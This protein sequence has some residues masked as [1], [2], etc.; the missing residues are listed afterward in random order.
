MTKSIGKKGLILMM[1]AM[2]CFSGNTMAEVRTVVGNDP[3]VAQQSGKVTGT[4]TDDF[5][6]VAGAAVL[7][8]GTTNGVVTDA[9]GRFTL[10]G[11]KNGA[12]I[13]VSYLGYTTQEIAFTGQQTLSIVLKEDAQTLDEVVVTALGVTKEAKALGYAVSTISAKELTKVGTP[14]FATALYGKAAGVRIYSAPGGQTS[15]VSMTVRGVSSMFGNTQPLL[16]MD[17]VPIRN[18]NANV[19][20]DARR[21]TQWND[22]RIQGNGIID[23][24][25]EDIENIS[26]LKGAA[27]SALYGS[28][29]ANGVVIVTSKKSAKNSGV[30]VDFSTTHSANMVA[31]MPK[32]QTEYGPGDL[33]TNMSAYELQNNGF[34]ERTWDRW[35]TASPQTY[36]SI[37]ASEM[38]NRN[39]FGAKYDGSDVLYWDGQVRPYSAISDSPYSDVFRTGYNQVYNVA[40]SHGGDKSSMR[41]SY[42]YVD[43]Q[44]TQY[45][46]DYSK[47]NFNLTG[48][49]NILN[50]LKIDYT[51]NYIRQTIHNRVIGIN[52][53][54]GTYAGMTG[55]F[56]DMA[57]MRDQFS[58][59]SGGYQYVVYEPT[60][61]NTLTPLETYAFQPGNFD[62]MKNMFY[63]M[64]GRNNDEKNQRFIA[65]V[66][67][68]WSI[69]KELTLRGRLSTDLT[70]EAQEERN[71]TERP[72]ALYPTDPGGGYGI[73]NKNYEI[74]YGDIMLMFNKDVADKLNLTA[75]V[76]FQGRL[77]E[78]RA[79][80]I[81]TRDGLSVDNWFHINASRNAQLETG[82]EYTDML[83]TA[84]FGSV[85]VSYDNTFYLEA[86]GRQETTSTLP[87]KNN[88]YFYP[89][90][91]ASYIFSEHLQ[92]Q[93]PWWDFGKLR[94]SYG[95]V[96]NA[97]D[98][99]RAAIVYNLENKDG[100]LHAST[101]GDYGNDD[102]K[103]EIKYEFEIGLESRFLNN[104][105]G[106][107]L[108]YYNNRVTDQLI[109]YDVPQT[110]GISRVWQNMG[111][112]K[113]SGVELT[114]SGTPVQTR[115]FRWD[116][117]FNYAVNKNEVTKLPEELPYLD[118]RAGLGNTGSATSVR[119]YVGRPV[120]EIFLHTRKEVNGMKVVGDY[121]YVPDSE[122]TSYGHLMPTAVGGFATTFAYKNLTLDMMFDFSVGGK[123]LETWHSYATSMGI[124]E[125]SLQYR[126][127]EHGGEAYYFE[128]SNSIANLREGV[129]PNGTTYYDG[130]RLTGVRSDP[131][132]TIIEKDADG[133]VI[134]TYSEV[135]KI[136]P[137]SNYYNAMYQGWGSGAFDE[138]L[139]DNSYLKCR[140]IS[141][142]Y[143]LPVSL[144]KKF[145]CRNLSLSLFGRNLFY[146]FKN[147]QD[148]DAESSISTSWSGTGSIENTAAATRTVGLSLRASF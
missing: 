26:I 51:A 55:A 137:A 127:A 54:F 112:L 140:E 9:D 122:W 135:S 35:G 116:L 48:S 121:G 7:V 58:V 4:V 87:A 8:K 59:T 49:L 142:S 65:S 6:P 145:G 71:N 13:R 30:Q 104:R 60:A 129:N 43:D 46:S 89:S 14:N 117:R 79:T 114:L 25:P 63:P 21:S 28:E 12:V 52:D 3:H 33:R 32:V 37:K 88:S 84:Y 61:K 22:K 115:D 82:M 130:V 74:Y 132:G 118:N 29:A 139:F 95:V 31:Y 94:L 128:G 42:T 45:N 57:L 24:N 141:L 64:M 105:A 108:S 23:I 109:Q 138:D 73:I 36:K 19:S 38:S 136:V 98:V 92:D 72:I 102:L 148:F 131:N 86:T 99:Y 41:F 17:G 2:I 106:L 69:I 120:G 76:G 125:K 126:D 44:P 101:P 16:V 11:V 56:D 70:A 146:I 111:E 18:G 62:I 143:R 10:E 34:Y 53:F 123:V 107:E 119:S 113:N 134:G 85:G 97:P 67:P 133:K 40:I 110:S 96:G 1:T 100:Y 83:R 91:N 147:L 47:H 20:D 68:T 124:T 81:R 27:A 66:A 15:G 78:S 103:A 144:S 93:L 5:G 90:V 80:R 50:N 77:E 39:Y 75:N